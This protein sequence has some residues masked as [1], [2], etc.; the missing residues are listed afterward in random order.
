MMKTNVMITAAI[1][2]TV[3]LMQGCSDTDSQEEGTLKV[4]LADSPGDFEAV[5]IVVE[6]V[7]VHEAGADSMSGWRVVNSIPGTY[8]VMQLRNGVTALLVDHQLPAGDYTQMRLLLGSGCNVVVEG[9]TH[10]LTVPSG[11]HSGLKLNHPFT[12]DDNG[13]Y[14]VLLDFDA[15]RSIHRTG[16][17]GEGHYMLRPV[18]HAMARMMSGSLRGVAMPIAARATVM[19]LAGTDTLAAWADTLSG[20]YLF[21]MLRE[22]T[23]DLAFSATAGAYHDTTL[24]GISVVRM[25]ETNVDTVALRPR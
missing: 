2:L 5:N 17:M 15:S 16:P 24:A 12:I 19:A 9:V 10:P 6:S 14:E 11:M 3:L 4:S 22:G 1:L 18:I 20:A 8:D 13:I 23:Y 21:P 25:Q 7:E